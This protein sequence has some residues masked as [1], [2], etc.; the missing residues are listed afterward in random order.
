MK[1]NSFT[2]ILLWRDKG[3]STGLSVKYPKSK[4]HNHI[5][6][7]GIAKLVNPKDMATYISSEGNNQ[8]CDQSKW[9]MDTGIEIRSLE[10]RVYVG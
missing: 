10:H 8:A 4:G 7:P 1:A 5:N 2:Y 3:Q 9:S 6:A